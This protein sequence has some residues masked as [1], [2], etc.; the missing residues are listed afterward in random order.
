MQVTYLF[1][2]IFF[3]GWFLLHSKPAILSLLFLLKNRLLAFITWCQKTVRF[4]YLNGLIKCKHW[5]SCDRFSSG[6]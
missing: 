6:V 4:I 3:L 5:V 2:T 1:V